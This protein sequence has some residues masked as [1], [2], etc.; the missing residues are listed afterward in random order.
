MAL[1]EMHLTQLD[2][3]L[4]RLLREYAAAMSVT[5]GR[6]ILSHTYREGAF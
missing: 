3:L 2:L 6:E 4:T 5:D 1:Q